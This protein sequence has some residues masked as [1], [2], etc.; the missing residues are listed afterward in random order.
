MVLGYHAGEFFYLMEKNL[1][2]M[3]AVP[4]RMIVCSLLMSLAPG[5]FPKFWSIPSLIS[6]NAPTINGSLCP[7]SHICVVSIS[8]SLYFESFSMTFVVVFRSPDG[9]D[10]SISLQHRLVL[11]LITISGFF[12]DSFLSVCICIS[13]RITTSSFSVTVSGLCSCHLPGTSIL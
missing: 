12:A 5:I 7:H 3:C 6:P 4:M 8:R 11:S 2:S 10:T 9:T 1:L 13:Q